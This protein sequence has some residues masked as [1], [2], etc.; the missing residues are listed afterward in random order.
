MDPAGNRLE[1]FL[2]RGTFAL[3]HERYVADGV[4]DFISVHESYEKMR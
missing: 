4:E 2:T 3:T 1:N